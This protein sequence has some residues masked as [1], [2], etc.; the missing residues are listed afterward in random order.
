MTNQHAHQLLTSFHYACDEFNETGF[1]DLSVAMLEVY[2]RSVWSCFDLIKF[3]W[4]KEQTEG[5]RAYMVFA[6]KLMVRLS[7]LRE[8]KRKE[9]SLELAEYF[10]DFSYKHDLTNYKEHL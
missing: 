3:L 6:G 1:M 4:S 10:K 9:T 5:T 2:Q 8:L 7:Y